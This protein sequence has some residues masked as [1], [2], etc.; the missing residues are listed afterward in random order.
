MRTVLVADHNRRLGELIGQ[1]LDDDHAFTVVGVVRSAEV[2]VEKSA[3]T[4]PDVVLVS[5]HLDGENGLALCGALRKA[6][7]KAALLLWTADVTAE[8]PE[9]LGADGLVERGMSYREL[10]RAVRKVVRRPPAAVDLRDGQ[11]IA[12]PRW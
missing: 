3:S 10:A 4:F 9:R 11:E 12:L 5:E 2:A 1:L 6:A 7:P 8:T